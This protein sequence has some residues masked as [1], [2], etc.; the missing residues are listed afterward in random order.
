MGDSA[1]ISIS[2]NGEQ[3]RCSAGLTLPELLEELGYKPA[4]VV[5]EF[6]GVIL[7]RSSW[8][9]QPVVESDV[10]EVVTIVGGGS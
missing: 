4:L 3:R 9:D 10:L 2:V 5:V 7:S 8:G 6:N 1:A